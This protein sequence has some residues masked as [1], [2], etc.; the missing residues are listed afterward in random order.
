LRHSFASIAD[1][2]GAPAQ[3]IQTA[4]GHVHASTT[5]VYL[6]RNEADAALRMAA[7]MG[8]RKPARRAHQKPTIYKKGLA[9]QNEKRVTFVS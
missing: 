2:R 7:I 8:D 4:L 1:E 3:W 5:A 9:V 6:H